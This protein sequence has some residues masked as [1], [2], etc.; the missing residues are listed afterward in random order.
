MPLPRRLKE[1]HDILR[2][3]CITKIRARDA[4]PRIHSSMQIPDE[5]QSITPAV[6]RIHS[7]M[8]IP[9]EPQSITPRALEVAALFL[10]LGFTAFGGPAA[11]IGMM[12]DEV[13]KRRNWLTEQEYLD[14]LGAT[15]LIPGPNSTEMAIHIGLRRAGWPG[16]VLAGMGFILPA[17]VMVLALAWAYVRFGTRPEA[18]WLLYGIKPA[19]IAIIVQALWRLGRNA[20]KTVP[21]ASLAV[22]VVAL[23]AL[24]V[25]EIV[26][27]FA[28]GLAFMLAANGTRLRGTSLRHAGARD[29]GACA[30]CRRTGNGADHSPAVVPDLPK[31][32]RG[33]VRRRLCP[34]GIPAL[35]S[36][37]ALCLAYRPTAAGCCRH[38]T[39]DARAALHNGHLHWLSCWQACQV[40][41]LPHWASSCL[42][43]SLWPHPAH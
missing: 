13:V 31:D 11:H 42:H 16:F 34:V 32:W 36:R 6:P 27:L 43:L 33:V 26:L 12:H 4:F 9:D 22:V 15:N 28:G 7:S 1:V 2:L 18:A 14:A 30:R 17:V 3:H 5:P 21:L 39:G 29:G 19:V 10:K 20:L 24:R 37:G 35:R 38:R 25:N 41:S 8:Q 23:Y 40:R